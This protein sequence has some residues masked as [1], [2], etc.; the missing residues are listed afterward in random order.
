MTKKEREEI[1]RYRA[2]R[3]FPLHSPPHPEHGEGWYLITAATYEHKR[4][5]TAPKELSALEKNI[6]D[7]LREKDIPCAAWIVLPNGY[8]L[9]KLIFLKGFGRIIGPVHGRSSYYANMRDKTRGR[10]VWYKYSDRKIRSDLH[11]WTTVNYIHYNPVKHNFTSEMETWPW[12]SYQ[13]YLKNKGQVWVDEL[14]SQHPLH[15]YGK[16]WDEI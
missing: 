15:D 16:G 6:L 9:V 3:G 1:L 10:R 8:H 5:F 11:F 14:F 4:H 2:S 13:L 7:A 12:S